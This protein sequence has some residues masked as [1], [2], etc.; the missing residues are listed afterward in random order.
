MGF[1][2]DRTFFLLLR[3]HPVEFRVLTHWKLGRCCV[4]L[5]PRVPHSTCCHVT[6]AGTR[7]VT[8]VSARAFTA[9]KWCTQPSFATRGMLICAILLL[10]CQEDCRSDISKRQ[11]GALVKQNKVLLPK[12]KETTR[13]S[14]HLEITLLKS[15]SWPFLRGSLEVSCH[16]RLSER[17]T[18]GENYSVS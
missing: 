15:M 10:Y 4:M 9:K 14:G 1:I 16:H 7:D 11:S 8:I 13:S 2:A 6:P 18:Q 12:V 17:G 5:S 3:S